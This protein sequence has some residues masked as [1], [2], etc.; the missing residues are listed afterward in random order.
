MFLSA[1]MWVKAS[2]KLLFD[3]MVWLRW[4]CEDVMSC[5]T[6]IC[7]TSLQRIFST[8]LHLVVSPFTI[9]VPFSNPFVVNFLDTRRQ[10]RAPKGFIQRHCDWP[11][12]H[13]F[14]FVFKQ[15]LRRFPSSWLLLHESHAA[16]PSYIIKFTPLL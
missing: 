10:V 6:H 5:I 8:V 2:T 16:L 13:R 15:M 12:R 4:L 3:Y 1:S 7:G 14:S 9:S 11:F